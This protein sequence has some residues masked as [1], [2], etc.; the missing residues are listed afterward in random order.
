[1]DKRV[2]FR[3]VHGNRFTWMLCPTPEKLLEQQRERKPF[4][5]ELRQ[6]AKELGMQYFRLSDRLTLDQIIHLVRKMHPNTVVVGDSL[7]NEALR[8]YMQDIVMETGSEITEAPFFVFKIRDGTDTMILLSPGD[9][10][11]AIK[12]FLARS[13]EESECPICFEKDQTAYIF[14]KKCGNEICQK[15]FETNLDDTKRCPFCR[16]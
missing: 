15:C 2:H 12:R 6:L 4:E 1:M 3:Q 11:G 10:L 9:G 5:D 16:S 14:C 7:S 8:A 13:N